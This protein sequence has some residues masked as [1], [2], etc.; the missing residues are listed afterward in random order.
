MK[1]PAGIWAASSMWWSEHKAGFS[2]SRYML[3]QPWRGQD[4]DWDAIAGGPVNA[5][6][7][8]DS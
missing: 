1:S 8:D 6:D 5:D 2:G 4:L 7:S 3:A